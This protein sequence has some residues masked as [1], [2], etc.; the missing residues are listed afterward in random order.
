MKPRVLLAESDALHA[1]ACRAFLSAEGIECAAV[2]SGLDCLAYLRQNRPDLVVLDVD[3]PWG[4]GLG[5]LAELREEGLADLPVVLL[6]D[7]PDQIDEQ[8]GGGL[9]GAIILLKPLSPLRL[10]AHLVGILDGCLR[11]YS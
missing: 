11:L 4:S 8:L 7:G 2:T 10:T 3:L 1:A 5:V 6:T 9:P